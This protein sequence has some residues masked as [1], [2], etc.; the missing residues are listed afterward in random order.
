MSS[1]ADIPV[2]ETM[3]CLWPG[4]TTEELQS[5]DYLRLLRFLKTKVQSLVHTTNPL[6]AVDWGSWIS[7]LHELHKS[8]TKSKQDVFL[9]IRRD[10]AIDQLSDVAISRAVNMAAGI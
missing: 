4:L 10:I 1:Q 7:I 9:E 6:L 3:Q 2:V 5:D 8:P